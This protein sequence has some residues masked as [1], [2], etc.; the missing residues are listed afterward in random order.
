M[1]RALAHAGRHIWS[2]ATREFEI[3]TLVLAEANADA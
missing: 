3:D 2:P 1:T